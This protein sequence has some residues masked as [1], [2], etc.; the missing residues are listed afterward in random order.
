MS[1]IRP[2]PGPQER[3]L[4]CPADVAIYGGSAGGG[5]TYALTMEAGR[6]VHVPGFAAIV[7]RRL[8]TQITGGGSVWQESLG[9]LPALGG[10]PQAAAGA[11]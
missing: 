5:K 2:Q 10:T 4:A 8:S 1:D 11:D 9:I 7:F 3:F 6:H